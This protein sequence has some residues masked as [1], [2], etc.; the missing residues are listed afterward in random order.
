M[1]VWPMKNILLQ[2]WLA[3]W[4]LNASQGAKVLRIHR[5]KMSEY[6]NET[7]NRVLPIYIAAHIETFNQLAKSKA[8]KIIQERLK[9]QDGK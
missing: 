9:K 1:A 3:M 7:S 4:S 6:L 8:Q 2:E 5:S